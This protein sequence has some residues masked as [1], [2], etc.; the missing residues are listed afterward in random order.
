MAK[1]LAER[2]FNERTKNALE[3]RD[4]QG[5]EKAYNQYGT[6]LELVGKDSPVGAVRVF[7][8]IPE[9]KSYL[10]REIEE[11]ATTKVPSDE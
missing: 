7:E 6:Y 11:Q 10:E 8:W 9:G 2:K 1:T 3:T 5:V 4:F